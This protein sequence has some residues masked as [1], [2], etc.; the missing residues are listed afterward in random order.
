MVHGGAYEEGNSARYASV[1]E[2]GEKFVK[3]DIIVVAIQYRLG[4]G[5]LGPANLGP[6]SPVS[7]F[8]YGLSDECTH[9]QVAHDIRSP[10]DIG[11]KFAGPKFI[12]STDWEFSVNNGFLSEYI[13][14]I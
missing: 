2:I 6:M 3:K 12:L 9:I 10:G 14:F 8:F 13:L 11:P 1:E 5:N 7:Q 4:L